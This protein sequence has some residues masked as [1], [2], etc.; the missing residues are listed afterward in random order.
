MSSAWSLPFRISDK[1]FVRISHPHVCHTSDP[2]HPLSDHPINTWRSVQVMKLII[3]QSFR[4]YRHDQ[5]SLCH[6]HFSSEHGT[7]IIQVFIFNSEVSI[8]GIIVKGKFKTYNSLKSSHQNVVFVA[9]QTA[10]TSW[11]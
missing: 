8:T 9:D 4:A 6:T 11:L 2:S 10:F 1:I 7:D 5:P 3:M